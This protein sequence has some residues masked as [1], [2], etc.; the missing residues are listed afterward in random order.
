M[1]QWSLDPFLLEE[2]PD[3]IIIDNLNVIESPELTLAFAILNEALHDLQLDD[4]PKRRE[5]IDWFFED[6]Y[7]YTFSFI[8]IANNFNLDPSAV[9]AM[10]RSGETN[11]AFRK[12][13]RREQGDGGS[14]DPILDQTIRRS[15][16]DG[17]SHREGGG[18]PCSSESQGEDRILP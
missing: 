16:R 4:G 15:H 8:N 5:A 18:N 10:I 3:V 17:A 1:S 12:R 6:Q 11:A 13:R 7:E 14:G 9:R 2:D